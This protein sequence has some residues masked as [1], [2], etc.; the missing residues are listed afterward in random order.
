ML[1][2]R[3]VHAPAARGGQDAL[4]ERSVDALRDHVRRL[5][6]LGAHAGTA[7]SSPRSDALQLGALGVVERTQRCAHVVAERHAA[8]RADRLQRGG[9]REALERCA[10]GRCPRGRLR[11]PLP[12][13][14]GDELGQRRGEC[15]DRSDGAT[16]ETAVDQRFGPHEDVE[17]VDQVR[18]E[19]LPGRFGDL[20]AGE[21]RH[22][23]AQSLDHRQRHGVAAAGREGVDVERQRG[24]GERRRRQVLEQRPV[25]EREVRGCDHRYTDGA[26][27]GRVRRQRGGVRRRLGAA[28]GHDREPAGGREIRLQRATALGRREQHALARGAAH[29]RAVGAAGAQE[30]REVPDRVLVDLGA[31]R[32]ER[33]DCRCEHSSRLH[34][35]EYLTLVGV[36]SARRHVSIAIRTSP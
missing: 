14:G 2:R 34:G 15:R 12:H 19:A 20:Q 21:V 35:L 7:S 18:L 25:V 22:A 33:R 5:A 31:S 16:R 11:R 23:L 3:A 27:L 9:H 17:P 30:R 24:A 32:A 26:G 36:L 6:G 8:Q 4:A 13:R 29:E 1:A 28:V 10:R